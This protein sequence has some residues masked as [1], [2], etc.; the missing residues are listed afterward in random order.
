MDRGRAR[1]GGRYAAGEWRNWTGDQVC[2]P[3]AFVEPRDIDEVVAAVSRARE[4]GWTVRAVGSG[5]S[6]TDAVLTDGMII[7]L[8]RMDRIVKIDPS[9]RRVRI[10][11]GITLKALNDALAENDLALENLGDVDVQSLAGATA[12]G[13]HGTGARF[14]NLSANIEE[15]DLV[16]ADGTL[17]T[18]SESTDLDAWRAARVNLGA[19][20]VVTGMTLKTLP[21]FVLKGKDDARPV[22]EVFDN[23]D[24]LVAEND[25]F[26]FY[27]WPYSDLSMTRTNNRVDA[28]PEDRSRLSAWTRDMFL[29]NHVLNLVCMTGRRFPSMIP[30][31][32][33][34]AALLSEGDERID[35]SYRIFASP[36]LV[37]FTETEYAVPRDT[38]IDVVREVKALVEKKRLDIPLPFEVRFVASDDALLS[39]ASGRETAYVAVHQFR[40]MEW[41]PF[42][43]SVRSIMDTVQGRPHWG[44]RHFETTH[45]LR[46]RFPR[47]DRFAEV[48]KRL[49]P[50]GL[51]A[52]EHVKR[53]LGPLDGR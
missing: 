35:L 23:L 16:L 15:L 33:R 10:E 37:R 50:E 26:E 20:G 28:P 46:P 12:T 9:T 7:S 25:H 14:K 36:R 53:V 24:A 38:V 42:F 18:L 27:V 39:P 29:V 31:L 49:D 13:T 43:R 1:M 19:L 41:E 45:T 22:K 21:A 51:F 2:R 44:K 32:N 3:A 8:R 52:N 17:T 30:R 5:H 6:F 40:K 4:K 48:R 34:M 47:W 11:G